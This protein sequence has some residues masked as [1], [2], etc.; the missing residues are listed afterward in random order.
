MGPGA[1]HLGRHAIV[2]TTLANYYPLLLLSLDSLRRNFPGHPEIIVFQKG[3]ST[4][5]VGYLVAR[6][7]RLRVLD[8]TGREFVCG[9]AMLNRN[10]KDPEVFYA[11]FLIWTPLFEDYDHVLYLDVDTMVMRPLD[12]LFSQDEFL[13]FAESYTGSQPYFYN[14]ND[15]ELKRLLA[16]DGFG[17]LPL[18]PANAGVILI[19][20]RYRSAGQIQELQRLVDRYARHL[21]WGD[22]SLINLWMVQNRL[23]PVHDFRFNYQVR[24]FIQKRA[25]EE[26]REVRIIHVS[27]MHQ[28][29]VIEYM[30]TAVYFFMQVLP[31]GRAILPVFIRVHTKRNGRL[32]KERLSR[33]LLTFFSRTVGRLFW[34]L[35][36]V[37]LRLLSVQPVHPI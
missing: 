2:M 31:A 10:Y 28:T 16:E 35:R 37:P 22:Q 30:M 33:R 6:Y 17:Q 3:F 11:R 1:A 19:P 24:L 5:Q 9:P 20:R 32:R 12:R 21:I 14:E 29:G 18:P 26:Y 8:L 34:V 23:Q 36:R 27:G 13:C 15:P 7:E 4:D 25:V